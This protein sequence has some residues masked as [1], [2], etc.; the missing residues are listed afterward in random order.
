MHREPPDDV[1][2]RPLP[3][4]V[5]V[6]VLFDLTMTDIVGT[7][8]VAESVTSAEARRPDLEFDEVHWRIS[9]SRG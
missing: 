2:K 5:I 3:A 7:G 6:F 4:C 8:S 9:D 1:P